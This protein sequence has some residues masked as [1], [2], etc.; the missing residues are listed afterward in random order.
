MS[1]LQIGMDIAE[2]SPFFFQKFEEDDW[3]TLLDLFHEGFRQA[4]GDVY[5][6]KVSFDERWDAG[7]RKDCERIQEVLKRFGVEKSIEECRSLW[8]EY[9]DDMCA[10]WLI[11]SD[12]DEQLIRELSRLGHIPEGHIPEGCPNCDGTGRS[13]CPLC[14]GTNNPFPD[15]D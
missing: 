9:S 10:T 13:S 14:D 6:G 1:G 7:E 5:N 12:S 2:E 3:T 15:E 4:C 8:S 11:V